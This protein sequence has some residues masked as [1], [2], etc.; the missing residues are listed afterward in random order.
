M[1]LFGQNFQIE[2]A[3]SG[4]N[5]MKVI[6]VSAEIHGDV[7]LKNTPHSCPPKQIGIY[8]AIFLD[9]LIQILRYTRQIKAW[10]SYFLITILE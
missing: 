3:S 1:G 6:L 8:N 7:S 2:I 5:T 9:V 4:I 10:I